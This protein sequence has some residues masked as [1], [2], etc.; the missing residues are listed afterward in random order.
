[1]IWA[2]VSGLG[3]WKSIDGGAFW[4]PASLATLQA[5]FAVVTDPADPLTVYAL[6]TAGLAKT[7]D[8]GATWR[9]INPTPVGA[10]AIAPGA[11][12][13]L[14]LASAGDIGNLA[15]VSRSDDG[16]ATW[17]PLGRLPPAT[18]GIYELDVDP[19][20]P[21]SVYVLGAVFHLD[22]S[23]AAFHSTDGGRSWAPFGSLPVF[24]Y[25]RSLRFDPRAPGTLLGLVAGELVR[26]RNGGASWEVVQ[27]GL[28][29]QASKTELALDRS[30]GTFYLAVRTA[31]DLGEVWKSADGGAS[32]TQIAERPGAL[33]P[34]VLDGAVPGRFYAGARDVGLLAGTDSAPGWKVASAGFIPPLAYNVEADPFAPG[35]LYALLASQLAHIGLVSSLPE[36]ARSQDG[37]VTWQSWTPLD[38]SG[39][40]IY[41]SELVFDPFVAGSIYNSSGPVLYHSADGGRSW[42]VAGAYPAGFA[43]ASSVVADPFH[44]GVLF[45]A[46]PYSRGGSAI[47]RSTDR[48]QSWT[49]VFDMPEG[50]A[51]AN[52][53]LADPSTPGTLFAGGRAGF[54]RSLDGG[55]T[56][57]SLAAG[58]P[59]N[60]QWMVRLETD[61]SRN[62]YAQIFPAGPHT[63]YRSGDRGA[64]WAPIDGGLPAGTLVR[65]LLIQGT[66]LYAATSN[67]VYVSEDGGG[68]WTVANDGLASASA[69]R[70]A[71]GPAGNLYVAT[72]GGLAVSPPPAAA[73]RANDTVLCLAG[74]RFALGVHW[75][76]PDGTAGDAHV[77]PLTNG[78]GGF[79]FFSPQ[80]VELIV[81][82]VDGRA[83]NGRYWLFGGA[84][85]D[86]AYTLTVTEVATGGVRTYSN[87]KGRLA[88]FADTNAF[89]VVGSARRALVASSTLPS[90][91]FALA[92]GAPCIPAADVLCLVDSRFAVRVAWRLPGTSAGTTSTSAT[93]VP[94]FQNTGAFWFFDA[95]NPELVVKILDGRALNGRFWV[96]FAGLSSVDYTATV[97]DTATGVSK[98]YPHPA[99]VLAS[100]ADTWF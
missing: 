85:S 44:A 83:V 3:V 81:K 77:S 17:R 37:G 99:G 61:S 86:V 41:L 53:L 31:A 49:S 16:G 42:A 65:D 4:E 24:G 46:G 48:G 27:A 68:R 63:L 54:W 62:L 60:P 29:R 55:Q 8:G 64:T 94:L 80:S 34:L 11:P 92:A 32:W 50:E 72:E 1:V 57:A 67:G 74:G 22:V 93:A 21:E 98:S 20:D 82:M 79:W 19:R 25:L 40:P 43:G 89:A 66:A 88:S 30:S 10:L 36:L 45:A 28:P 23:P 6:G 97:T 26:S 14:Y 33:H 90:A 70:L 76:L 71:A 13:T 15:L 56:W 9:V 47:L 7:T 58:F 95:S 35:T 100:S 73:C 39:E 69:N 2:A 59:A 91:G 84:L 5:Y 51:F 12:R 96:F 18:E 75:T 78:S 52:V 87:P 38:P